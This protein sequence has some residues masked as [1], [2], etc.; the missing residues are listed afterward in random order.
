VDSNIIGIMIWDFQGRV[1]EANEAFLNIVG[2]THEDVVLGR[3]RWR[4]LTPAEWHDADDQARAE[5]KAAGTVQPR[6]KEYFRKDGS[7]VPVLLGATT[8][9]DKQDEGVAFVLDLTERKRAEL[10][11]RLL[12]SLVEQAAD[13]MAIADLSGGAPLYLNRAGLE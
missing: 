8:F 10:E 9:G 12:A 1:I 6:E 2:Y 5:L 13:F 3:L 11:R 7:R 4:D